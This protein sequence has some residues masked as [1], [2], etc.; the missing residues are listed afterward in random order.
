MEIP[1]KNCLVLVRCKLRTKYF[2]GPI[3]QLRREC[4][5]LDEYCMKNEKCSGEIWR[6]GNYS[7]ELINILYSGNK[8]A[9]KRNNNWVIE[10]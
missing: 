3:S 8:L 1:C 7:R 5:L 6:G 2:A 4:K 10:E 9:I